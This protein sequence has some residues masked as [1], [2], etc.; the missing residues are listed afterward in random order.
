[1]TNSYSEHSFHIPVMGVAFTIDSPIKVAHYG[2][3]SVISMVDD[4]LLEQ[5]RAYY[6]Q[7]FNLAYEEISAKVEDFRAKRITAYLNMV[8]EIVQLKFENLKNA[9]WEKGCELEKYIQLLPDYATL[10]QDFYA[11]LNVAGMTNDVRQWVN[12]NLKAGS[13]DINIMTK[14]DRENFSGAEKLPSEFNDAHAALRGFANSNLESSVV[15]SAGLNPR[16]YSYFE[17]FKDFYPNALGEL[18]KQIILK[19][20]DYRSALIQGKFLAKKGLWVSEFRM[21]SGLN[22]G[23]HAFATDGLLM[24][25]ILEEFKQHREELKQ[26]LFEMYSAALKEKNIEVPAQAFEQKFTAQGGVGTAQ[27]QDMLREQYTLDSVGWG[28]TFLLVPEATTVDDATLTKLCEAKEKDLYL[29]HNSPL[30]VRFNNI[31]DNSMANEKEFLIQ[32]NRPGSACPKKFSVLNKDYTE[33]PIC[34][35]SRQYQHLRLA[36]LKTKDLSDKEFQKQFEL[37][38]AKECLCVGLTNA[39][40]MN[41]GIETKHYK[42]SVSICPGPNLAYYDHLVSLT[43]MVDHIYGRGNILTRTDRPH[44]FIKELELYLNF[45]EEAIQDS[46]Q[47]LSKQ[48]AT[49]L[50]TFEKNLQEGIAYYRNLFTQ[51]SYTNELQSLDQQEHRLSELLVEDLVA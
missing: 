45:F 28:S 4:T 14:L 15:L 1:M 46:E 19:I 35:A 2:I 47:P 10:K 38:T 12:R 22:C 6:C 30:G 51:L 29:S 49:Y 5:L 8:Q 23:G 27:E 41:Y 18:K 32:K 34:T 40:L 42:D 9:A 17:Q 37:A 16:L 24:G 13:I 25:P 43:E 21:E 33:E 11:K 36:D 20:S 39:A 3:S 50:K 7:Q 31:R 48:R 26:T 44:M